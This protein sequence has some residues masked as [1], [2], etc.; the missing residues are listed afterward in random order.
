MGG[1]KRLLAGEEAAGRD[2]FFEELGIKAGNL[3][4]K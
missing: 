4:I 3:E 2:L 1:P